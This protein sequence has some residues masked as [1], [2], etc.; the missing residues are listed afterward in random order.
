MIRKNVIKNAGFIVLSL[1]LTFQDTILSLPIRNTVI[2]KN[3]KLNKL[4]NI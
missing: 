1:K 3:Q 4:F 2:L